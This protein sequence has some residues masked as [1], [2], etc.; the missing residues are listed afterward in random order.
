MQILL[1]W[2]S[3]TCSRL[4]NTPGRHCLSMPG[5]L[6][7]AVKTKNISVTVL[8]VSHMMHWAPLCG[9]S[10]PQ[11]LDLGEPHSDAWPGQASPSNPAVMARRGVQRAQVHS[12]PLASAG[13]PR[14]D[15]RAQ[16]LHL[17]VHTGPDTRGV[18]PWTTFVRVTCGR[19]AV[20]WSCGTR[21]GSHGVST[22]TPAFL[23]MVVREAPWPSELLKGVPLYF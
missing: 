5:A 10:S 22:S 9:V 6:P 19:C 2:S 8:Q 18:L 20:G 13:D 15:G 23:R 4:A 14:S 17:P 16:T 7:R 1:Q 12:R 21:L 3:S 11:I